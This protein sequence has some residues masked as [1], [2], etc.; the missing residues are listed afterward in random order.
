[1]PL[2]REAIDAIAAAVGAPDDISR[3]LDLGSGAGAASVALAQRF[4]LA[5][6]TAV[7]GSGPLLNLA[8][9]RAARAGVADRVAT[10]VADLE[11]P[12]DAVAM[13]ASVDVIW[14]SM[15]LHHTAAPPQ[16]LSGI[17]RL[18]RPG[19]VLAVLEFGRS[20]DT[21][22]M[23]FG[24]GFEGFAQRYAEVARAVVEEHLPQGAMEI[25]WPAVLGEAGFELVEEREL[26]MRLPAPLD[27][28][29]RHLVL[30]QLQGLAQRAAGRLAKPDLE[31][32]DALIDPDDPRCALFRDDM[33]LAVS[34]T[35]LLAR[36]R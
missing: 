24:G 26:E 32:L 33:S 14:A 8:S 27:E 36:P 28:S 34:R 9:A 2:V 6:V 30:H 12:L 23:R 31:I 1:M 35:L 7:D 21:L 20:N 5:A 11:Q 29:A 15:V 25:G 18:L 19:G 4:P 17:R 3:V 16:A 10:L 13:A 22:P